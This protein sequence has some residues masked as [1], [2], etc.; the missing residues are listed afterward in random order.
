[1]GAKIKLS[2][3]EMLCKAQ[4]QH[5]SK[6]TCLTCK[7]DIPSIEIK[8]TLCALVEESD[9]TSEIYNWMSATNFYTTGE[10]D[11]SEWRVSP[12]EDAEDC[13]GWEPEEGTCQE[14]K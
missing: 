10:S 1:M 4:V 5:K 9:Y 2:N 13:P 6:R 8:Q 3:M 14:D 7:H 11:T 12:T